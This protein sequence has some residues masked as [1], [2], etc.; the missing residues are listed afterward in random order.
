VHASEQHAARPQ[1]LRA[2]GLFGQRRG[3]LDGALAALQ[4]SA[5]VARSQHTVIQLGRTLA[6]LGKLARQRGDVA[7]AAQADAELASILGRIGPEVQALP[8]ASGMPS[9]RRASTTD[10]GP[11]SPREREVAALIAE[12]RSNRQI[13][14]ALVISERTAEHH[15]ESIL[16]KLRLDSRTQV[17]AWAARIDRPAVRRVDGK[18]A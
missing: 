12:G 17:A 5:A 14:D 10:A 13:A 2:H 1:I 15:V 3:K 11:L 16:S 6:T 9:L 18:P 4:A 8:W 7:L